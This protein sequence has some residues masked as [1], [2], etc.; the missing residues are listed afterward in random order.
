MLAFGIVA[1][2]ILRKALFPRSIASQLR[3]QL[4][5]LQELT[6]EFGPPENQATRPPLSADAACSSCGAPVENPEQVSP[7]GDVQC[8]HCGRW[9]NVRG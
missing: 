9:F 6:K 5:E 8:T 1:F 7:N 2:M 3:G 4:Q